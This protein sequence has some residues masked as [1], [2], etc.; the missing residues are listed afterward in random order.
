[1]GRVEY[2][3][4]TARSGEQLMVDFGDQGYESDKDLVTELNDLATDGWRVVC[5]AGHRLVLERVEEAIKVV[6]INTA[7]SVDLVGEVTEEGVDLLWGATPKEWNA[8]GPRNTGELL[9]D[10]TDAQWDDTFDTYRRLVGLA[11]KAGVPPTEVD[12]W[13]LAGVFVPVAVKERIAEL[14]GQVRDLTK[15]CATRSELL[16]EANAHVRRLKDELARLHNERIR[17]SEELARVRA[18]NGQL[19]LDW[20]V[21]VKAIVDTS[22]AYISFLSTHRMGP[23]KSDDATKA[24]EL[25]YAWVDA[26]RF[27]DGP[28]YRIDDVTIPEPDYATPVLGNERRAGPYGQSGTYGWRCQACGSP[29]WHAIHT[30]TGW[31]KRCT[32]CSVIS[33]VPILDPADLP[34]AVPDDGTPAYGWTC[35]ACGGHMWEAVKIYADDSLAPRVARKACA[36]CGFITDEP[37]TDAD[38]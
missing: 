12:A 23:Y 37:V 13:E 30:D 36:D 25:Y 8:E 14:T 16:E 20:S 21:Q 18:E 7:R 22:R 2:C 19:A 26:C 3:T 27:V 32:N 31:L 11:S 38:L 5:Y 28:Q 1:M 29:L 15:E 4:V 33:D 34:L 9:A 6:N 17:L 24:A 10:M 35:K